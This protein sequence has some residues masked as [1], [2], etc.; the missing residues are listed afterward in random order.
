MQHLVWLCQNPGLRKLGEAW[1]AWWMVFLDKTPPGDVF[2]RSGWTG[3]GISG[4]KDVARIVAGGMWEKAEGSEKGGE[5]EKEKGKEEEK[6]KGKE[7]EQE[8]GQEEEQEKGQEEEQDNG[9]EEEQDNGQEEE[10]DMT[11]PEHWQ[12]RAH[13]PLWPSSA[14]KIKVRVPSCFIGIRSAF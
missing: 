14:P 11:Y 9:Q 10:Q 12:R 1:Q 8:K 4:D 7:E 2:S 5:E 3:A 13:Q 6:E